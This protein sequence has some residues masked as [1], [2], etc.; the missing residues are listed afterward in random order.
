MNVVFDSIASLSYA[1]SLIYGLDMSKRFPKSIIELA[2]EPIFRTIAYAFIYYLSTVNMKAAIGVLI[3][4]LLIHID[5]I[6]LS[7]SKLLSE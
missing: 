7:T 1:F 3:A 2:A 6:N 5:S 4:F